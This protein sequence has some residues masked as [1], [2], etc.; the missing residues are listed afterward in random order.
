MC[1]NNYGST[2]MN[3]IA[4]TAGCFFFLFQIPHWSRIMP[5]NRSQADNALW[6]SNRV[7]EAVEVVSHELANHEFKKI[8]NQYNRAS[9]SIKSCE[10]LQFYRAAAQC[11]YDVPGGL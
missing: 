2:I 5:S 3:V 11:S 7:N 1:N 6:T 8:V 4:F 10:I 9:Q